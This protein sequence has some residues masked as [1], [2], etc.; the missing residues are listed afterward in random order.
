MA[1]GERAVPVQSMLFFALFAALR[2]IIFG[3]RLHIQLQ[4]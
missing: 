4:P 2:E 3:P 1:L